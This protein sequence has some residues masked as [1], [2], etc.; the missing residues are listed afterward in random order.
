MMK[1]IGKENPIE[2]ERWEMADIMAKNFCIDGEE[3]DASDFEW[4]AHCLQQEGFGNKSEVAREIF[5]EIEKN[6]CHDISGKVTMYMLFAEE[7]AE[8]KNKYTEEKE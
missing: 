5:E 3:Y 4:T 6:E 7:L 8:L 2:K 1:P